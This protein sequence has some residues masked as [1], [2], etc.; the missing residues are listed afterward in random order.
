MLWPFEKRGQVAQIKHTHYVTS[1][2]DDAGFGKMLNA[3]MLN[4]R[5]FGLDFYIMNYLQRGVCE[6]FL[7][8]LTV[9]VKV[10]TAE[11]SETDRLSG[12]VIEEQTG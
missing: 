9:S 12:Q 8:F 1:P 4:G 11:R 7:I 6:G 3:K 10:M 5:S 2:T